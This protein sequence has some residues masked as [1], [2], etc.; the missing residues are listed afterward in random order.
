MTYKLTLIKLILNYY[1][2]LVPIFSGRHA[3]VIPLE[4]GRINDHT[5]YKQRI[6][7][8][9]L[10]QIFLS[11]CQGIHVSFHLLVNC[12]IRNSDSSS[13]LEYFFVILCSQVPLLPNQLLLQQ[14]AF[15]RKLYHSCGD[16]SLDG[17]E[18]KFDHNFCKPLEPSHYSVKRHHYYMNPSHSLISHFS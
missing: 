15:Q 8:L 9:D 2:L 18:E 10:I 7:I 14:L 12:S 17:Q 3:C 5:G 6:L 1:C 13:C 11:A 16:E 4:L